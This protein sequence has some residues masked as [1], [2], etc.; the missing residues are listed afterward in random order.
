MPADDV[1]AIRALIHEYAELIDTGD[2]DSLA[3]LF[4]DATWGSPGRGTPLRGTEQ[5]RRGDDGVILYDGIPCTKHVIS[6]V[7]VEITDDGGMATARSY[8]TVLQA[9][10]Y[11]PLQPIIAGRYR[12]PFERVEGRWRFADRQ[13]IPDLIGDLSR[14]LRGGDLWYGSGRPASPRSRGGCDLGRGRDPRRRLVHAPARHAESRRGSGVRGPCA[15]C[16]R[17][18]TVCPAAPRA[19]GRCGRLRVAPSRAGRTTRSPSRGATAYLAGALGEEPPGIDRAVAILR[20][21]A[22]AGST[23]GHAVYGGLRSLP[24]PDTPLGDLFARSD[25]IRERRGG[26]HLNVWTAA[27]LSSV[28]IQ[29]LTERWR[30]TSWPGST[31]ADQMS[32]FGEEIGEALDRFRARGFVDGDGNLTDEGREFREGIE[33]ATDAQEADLVEALGEDVDE[34]FDLMAPWARAVVAGAGRIT[35]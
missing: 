3:G 29:L 31:T 28:E 35:R 9:R 33:R 19:C 20:P 27:G 30:T 21:V 5:V 8:F 7:T 11:L 1:E 10:P 24:W 32:Y 25:M 2:L 23:A 17:R 18:G 12:E 13:I 26:S 6:N 22:E 4:A 14:H 16:G 34:L 15:R